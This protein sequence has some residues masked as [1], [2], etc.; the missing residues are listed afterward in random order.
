MS[1]L[2]MDFI[3]AEA[4]FRLGRKAE[5]AA[6]INKTRVANG[7][8]PEVTVDGPPAGRACVPKKDDG[9]CGD[10]W[11]ALMYEK[12]LET[13]GLEPIIPFADRRGWG[14]LMKGSL[15]HFPVTGRELQ[16]LG[17]PVYTY[18]GDLPGSAP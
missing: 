18:G 2:E 15:I 12:R 9:T 14:L 8:L 13:Y 1:P 4:L 6:I 16:T 10:L 11:D 17:K 5:A 7:K 3:R